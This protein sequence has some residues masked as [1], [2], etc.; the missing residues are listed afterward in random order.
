MPSQ[1]SGHVQGSNLQEFIWDSQTKLTKSQA[2]KPL[3][4]KTLTVEI[5]YTLSLEDDEFPTNW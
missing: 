3:R 2:V 5:N 1:S 4:V